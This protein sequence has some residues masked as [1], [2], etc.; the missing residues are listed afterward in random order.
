LGVLLAQDSRETVASIKVRFMQNDVLRHIRLYGGDER[1]LVV[2]L[3]QGP[4]A[5]R[6]L[7]RFNQVPEFL[8]E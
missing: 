2:Y 3:S 6:L 4:E 5:G 7:E 8:Q 1:E